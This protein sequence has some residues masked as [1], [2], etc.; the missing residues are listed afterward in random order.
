MTRAGERAFTL[1]E[2]SMVLVI[3]GLVIMI[4]FPALTAFRQ[5]M[6]T[7]ATHNNLAALMRATAAFAQANGC[8]PCPTPASTTG[9]GFGRVRG[10]ASGDGCQN[11]CTIHEG[12]VPYVSLGLSAQT[13]K[14]GWGRWITMRVDPALVVNFGVIPPTA[15]CL[16]GDAEP[17]CVIGQSRK[18]LCRSGLSTTNRVSVT[19]PGGAT[20]E[21]ALIFVSHGANGWGAFRADPLVSPGSNGHPSFGGVLTPCSAAGGFERCNANGDR[22][23][24]DAPMTVDPSAPYDDL[25]LYAGRD[26]LVSFLGNPACQTTW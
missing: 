22:A 16:A 15:P 6:Q 21:A 8:V 25:V 1:V 23:F 18:G 7:T 13:A 12:I 14:D 19:I 4:V 20:Q 3:M 9:S 26:A 24:V 11:D 2:T 10:D 17:S 5:S